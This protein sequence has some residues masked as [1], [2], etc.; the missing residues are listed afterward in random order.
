MS[1][2]KTGVNISLCTVTL[3]SRITVVL[4]HYLCPFLMTAREKE[5]RTQDCYQTKSVE[6][7]FF[8]II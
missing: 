6:G 2:N 1:E 5:Y 4:I 8:L 7:L 3:I